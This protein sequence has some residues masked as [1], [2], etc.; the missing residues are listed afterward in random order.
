[1]FFHVRIKTKAKRKDFLSAV[2]VSAVDIIKDRILN[3][4]FYPVSMFNC[5]YVI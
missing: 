3:E 5:A 1:M 2:K 4:V